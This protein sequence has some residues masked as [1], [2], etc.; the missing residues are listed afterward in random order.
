M[1]LILI[2]FLQDLKNFIDA[3]NKGVV[4]FSLGSNFRS[5]FMPQE[6]QN[7]F[8]NI[9]SDL[10]DYNFLWKFES[11]S[12][13]SNMPCNVRIQPW[14]P[15]SDI[16]AHSKVKAIFFHG[17]MLT[18]QEALWRGV[19]MIIMPFGLDQQQVS[20]FFLKIISAYI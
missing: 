13:S 15:V 6:K 16:L 3:S 4:L 10:R 5:D 11:N 12:P 18:T 9:F 1:V 14:L 17:G 2:N 20:R 8:I 19:P 7:I